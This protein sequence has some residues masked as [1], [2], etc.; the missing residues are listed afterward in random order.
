MGAEARRQHVGRPAPGR[1]RAAQQREERHRRCH[2]RSPEQ[3]TG[4]RLAD[5][6]TQLA[7]QEAKRRAVAPTKHEAELPIAAIGDVRQVHDGRDDLARHERVVVVQRAGVPGS[8]QPPLAGVG[9]RQ[10]R[11][12]RGARKHA[13]N[14]P[15]ERHARSQSAGRRERIIHTGLRRVSARRH[16]WRRSSPLRASIV[17]DGFTDCP[18]STRRRC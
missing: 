9:E 7:V 11:R 10:R 6:T 5:Q 16:R 3:G 18:T 2:Q 4:P 1:R 13:A 8:A 15:G 12:A 14:R 17:H